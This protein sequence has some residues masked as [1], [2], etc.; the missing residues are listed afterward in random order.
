[1]QASRKTEGI[2]SLLLY[3]VKPNVE[4]KFSSCR[5]IVHARNYYQLHGQR[6]LIRARRLRST[7]GGIAL[8][9]ILLEDP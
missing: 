8:Q 5:S 6:H 1:M 3:Y 9:Q 2:Q 7:A 4:R